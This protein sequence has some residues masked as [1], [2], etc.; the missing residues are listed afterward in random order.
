MNVPVTYPPHPVNGFL[1]TGL[2]S[3]AQGEITYPPGLL[4][5]YAAKLGPYRVSLRVQYKE[6]NEEAFLADALDLIGT[7]GRYAW[8]LMAD[9]PWDLFM[10]HFITLDNLQHALW[11]H[12][13]PTHPR[14]R[15]ELAGKYGDGLLRAYQAVDTQV[16]LLVE[17]A[18]TLTGAVNVIV[19]SDHGFG[20]LHHIVNLNIHLLKHGLLRLKRHPWTQL[21]AA[22]FRLGL[23][24]AG[25]Y[26]WL[27]RLG[28]QNIVVRVSKQSRNAAVGRFLSFQDVDW[29]HTVAYSMGHVGQVYLNRRGREPQG[30]VGDG[31]EYEEARNRV[32]GVLRQLTHPETG[33]PLLDEVIYGPDVTHGPYADQAPDLHL[34]LDGYRCITFPLF[35]TNNEVVTRQIRG[36]SGCHRGNGIFIGDGPAFRQAETVH[37]SRIIDL[38]PTILHLL[39]LQV[40]SNMDGRV[41]SEA[42]KVGVLDA[43]PLRIVQS[44][45]GSHGEE[46][47]LSAEETAEI[48]ERLRSLGYLG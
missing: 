6:G 9:Q 13:D 20:P 37:G 26:R 15:P 39:G 24:P 36:D 1:I 25:V 12:I 27:E 43:Q 11:K 45:D 22:L 34:I 48:E 46:T 28:V 5:P 33:K 40:P 2:L 10:V 32:V 29:R 4:A 14:Y 42:L 47:A 3:P 16:G 21:K 31:S 23:S 19:M 44:G 18:Q 8:H 30:I 38:A 41:L 7:R 35:A 17:Q